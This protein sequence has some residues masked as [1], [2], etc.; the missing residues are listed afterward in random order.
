MAPELHIWDAGFHESDIWAMGVTIY[1]LLTGKLPWE[2]HEISKM[3]TAELTFPDDF[4]GPTK[5]F[6][7]GCITADPNE[8]LG[9]GEH[10]DLEE[11]MFAMDFFNGI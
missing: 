8:R 7:R 1:E 10:D 2:N 6:I 5:D 11:V 3:V 4:D 9:W